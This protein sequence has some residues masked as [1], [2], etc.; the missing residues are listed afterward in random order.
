M[1]GKLI[2]C[3]LDG[4]LLNDQKEVTKRTADTLKEAQENGCRICFASGRGEKM[5]SIYSD[6]IEGCDYIVS[7]NGAMAR[8]LP[9]NKILYVA[10]LR[11]ADVNAI[12][13]Y[14]FEHQLSFMMYTVDR[15]FY[16]QFG[17]EMKKRV[18]SYE[19]KAASL[20]YPVC[21]PAGPLGGSDWR[22]VKLSQVVKIVIYEEDQAVMDQYVQFVNEKLPETGC[23]TTGYGL[24]GTFSKEV[25]KKYAVEHIKT[26]MGI[27]S[28]RVYVFGDYDNDLSMFECADHRI[29]MQ[30]ASESVKAA[31][32]FV[33]LS[34]NEDGVAEYIDREIIKR[35]QK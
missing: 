15:I 6:S 29:A 13:E 20:G 19:K 16:S 14:V 27:K 34:N 24:M 35:V 25:S 23:E 1:S 33:T 32:T 12:M 5:M 17:R 22:S 2:V 31:A 4:T 10:A 8:Y 28:D 26:H 21:L 11:D 18:A 3:D 30:N 7:C 9:E